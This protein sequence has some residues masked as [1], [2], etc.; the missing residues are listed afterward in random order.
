MYYNTFK[1]HTFVSQLFDDSYFN[2]PCMKYNIL[3]YK[4]D[5]YFK[6]FQQENCVRASAVLKHRT[7]KTSVVQSQAK[8]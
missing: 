8:G 6:E 5:A 7:E 2:L 4:D 3:I 1:T